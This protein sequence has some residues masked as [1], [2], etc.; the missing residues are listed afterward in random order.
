MVMVMAIILIIAAFTMP[1]TRGMLKG[2]RLGQGGQIFTDQ[3]GLA[4]QI[5]LST[6][7]S[8][9][10]RF[11]CYG[12]PEVPGES[13]DSADA[14]NFH[15]MQAFEIKE[16]G[17]VPLGAVVRLPTSIIIDKDTSNFS[18]LLNGGVGDGSGSSSP[19]K[20]S[21]GSLGVLI[22]RVG[23]GGKAYSSISFRFLPDGSTDLPKLDT[24]LDG[25][26]SS[27]AAWFL[28]LH[29]VTDK[30]AADGPPK[31]F[32]TIQVDPVNGNIHTYRP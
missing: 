16:S 2:S 12:D 28:T 21:G 4:R 32:F 23:S 11:Y 6:N 10:V 3:I 17:T 14:G 20:S 30:A 24:K 9:E 5:A 19:M 31:D 13:A 15:A 22:P 1:N 18:T 29:D 25:S 27:T 26:Q 7:H 8:V